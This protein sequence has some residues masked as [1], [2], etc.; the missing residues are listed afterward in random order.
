MDSLIVRVRAASVDCWSCGAESNIVSSI[1]LRRGD[2][3]IECSISDFTEYQHLVLQIAQ[4]LAGKVE[5]GAI[6]SRFSKTLARSYMSNGCAHCDALFGQHFEI[7][8][9][10]GEALASE[11]RVDDAEPWIAMME[12][13]RASDDGHLFR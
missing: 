3:A 1:E 8:T 13:L 6:K 7:H 4:S 10:H 11:M 2:V 9:R 12:A 5:V